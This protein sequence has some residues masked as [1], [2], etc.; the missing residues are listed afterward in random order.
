MSEMKKNFQIELITTT[1]TLPH[2][3]FLFFFLVAVVLLT[4]PYSTHEALVFMHTL[5]SILQSKISPNGNTTTRWRCP[6]EMERVSGCFGVSGDQ[7]GTVFWLMVELWI[8]IK[9]ARLTT[10]LPTFLCPDHNVR[11]LPITVLGF[12]I[13]CRN[14]QFWLSLVLVFGCLKTLLPP[15]RKVVVPQSNLTVNRI[16]KATRKIPGFFHCLMNIYKCMQTF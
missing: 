14:G 4:K 13:H 11:E 9:T 6:R 5:Y 15:Y 1:Q 8:C 12:H 2:I 10:L 16:S 3:K 7:V